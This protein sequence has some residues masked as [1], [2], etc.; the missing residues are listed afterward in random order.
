MCARK[1]FIFLFLIC[2]AWAGEENIDHTLTDAALVQRARG[3]QVARHV[4]QLEAEVYG[5]TFRTG[6]AVCVNSN[7]KVHQMAE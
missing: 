4:V 7:L 1:I 5:L 2:I 3:L 6:S